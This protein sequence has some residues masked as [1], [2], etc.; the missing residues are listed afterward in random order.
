[1]ENPSDSAYSRGFQNT[2]YTRSPVNPNP[3]AI[4]SSNHSEFIRGE[5]DGV[6]DYDACESDRSWED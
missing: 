3:Y 1:M 4:T 2:C 5:L 6:L